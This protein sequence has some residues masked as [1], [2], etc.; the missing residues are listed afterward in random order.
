MN[1]GTVKVGDF[2]LTTVSEDGMF[3]SIIGHKNYI[4]PEVK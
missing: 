1:D 4:P 2:G 3:K